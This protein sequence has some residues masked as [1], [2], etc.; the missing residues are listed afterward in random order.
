MYLAG[1]FDGHLVWLEESNPQNRALMEQW[2][3]DISGI[4]VEID[5]LGKL[6]NVMAEISQGKF[7][8]GA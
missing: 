5:S 8:V 3:Q 1:F 2:A 7:K 6:A 4:L